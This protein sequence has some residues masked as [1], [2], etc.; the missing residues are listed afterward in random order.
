MMRT[1]SEKTELER[2]LTVARDAAKAAGDA[3][4][5]QFRRGV[6][7]EWKGDESPVT[8]ADREAE[9]A[10]LAIIRAAFP[11]HT[12]LGEETGAH[13]GDPAWRWILDPLDGTRQFV[14]GA[15]LW[16]PLVALEHQGRVVAG[17]MALPV[18]GESYWGARGLGSWM[19]GERLRVSTVAKLDQATI[20]LGWLG[21]LMTDHEPAIAGIARAAHTCWSPGDLAGGAYVLSG[22]ADAWI[23][24]G[25][26]VWDHA[27]FPVLIEEAGGRF[28]DLNGDYTIEHGHALVTNGA[29]HDELLARLRGREEKR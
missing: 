7:V 18:I 19:N 10:M 1:L 3:A 16:G 13:T 4:L 21:G 24:C 12:I 25:V 2:A 23:D 9:A 22:R 8:T 26:R 29:L 5:R 28:S 15:P 14:R 6:P 11:R 17:A 27:P 20:C